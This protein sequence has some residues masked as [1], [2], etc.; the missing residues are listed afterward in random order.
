[1]EILIALASTTI[2]KDN[3]L[4]EGAKIQAYSIHDKMSNKY[5]NMGSHT[6]C[7]AAIAIKK[8]KEACK[9]YGSVSVLFDLLEPSGRMIRA[10]RGY[11]L[12]YSDLVMPYAGTQTLLKEAP[13]AA[14]EKTGRAMPRIAKINATASDVAVVSQLPKGA[15]ISRF[16]VYH[17]T[18]NKLLGKGEANTVKQVLSKLERIVLSGMT[19]NVTMYASTGD[20]QVKFTSAYKMKSTGAVKA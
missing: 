10:T 7:S 2:T 1:M 16:E 14:K 5:L 6:P 18:T 11:D 19:V 4:P 9:Q 20:E 8:I 13:S 12:K 15:K 3:L 17:Q